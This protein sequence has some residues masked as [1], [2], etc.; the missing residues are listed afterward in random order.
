MAVLGTIIKFNLQVRGHN[1]P[2]AFFDIELLQHRLDAAFG[3]E[4]TRILTDHDQRRI[5]A[6]GF[7]PRICKDT[8]PL[9]LEPRGVYRH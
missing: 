4:A 7:E 1:D 9:E 2:L 5:L 3:A 8:C 6:F